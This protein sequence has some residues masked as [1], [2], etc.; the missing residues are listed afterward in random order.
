MGVFVKR[1]PRKS[2]A[3]LAEAVRLANY[4]YKKASQVYSG[5]MKAAEEAGREIDEARTA[6]LVAKHLLTDTA[7]LP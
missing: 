1:E 4:Q 5:L 6:L 7:E 2:V 3:E